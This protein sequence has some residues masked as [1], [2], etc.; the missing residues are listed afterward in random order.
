MSLRSEKVAS[1][2]KRALSMP[3][4]ELARANSA[5]IATVT[6]VR[7]SPDLTVAKVYISVYGNNFPPARFLSAIEDQKSELRRLVGR[8]VRLRQTPD[9]KFFLDDT[10]DQIEHIQKIL[11]QA[12]VEDDNIKKQNSGE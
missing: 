1:V 10:L 8:S 3:V 7:M 11:D 6:A 5:G 9:I 12:K 4:S 2:I